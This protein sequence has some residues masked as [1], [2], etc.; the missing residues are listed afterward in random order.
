MAEE[1]INALAQVPGLRVAARTSTFVFKGK[2]HDLRAIG[3]KLNVA[4]VLEGS[5]RRAGNRVRITAQ[6]VSVSDGYHLWSERYDR[7]L[8]DIFAIQDEI[9]TAIASRLAVTLRGGENA[10][11]VRPSTS[12]LEAYELYLKAR[13]LLKERGPSLLVAIDLFERAVALDPG[14]APALA[15]LAQA[16]ILSSFWGMSAPERVIARATWAAATALEHDAGLVAAHVASALVATC[17]DFDHA[18]ATEAWNRALTIDPGDMDARTMRAAFDLCYTRG[19]FDASISELHAVVERDPLSASA[20]SQLSV[21]F[22]F[23]RRFEEAIAEAERARALAPQSFFVTWSYVNALAFG[24]DAREV[25]D[26]VPM[27][28]PRHGR[29]PWLMMGLAAAYSRLGLMEQADGIYTELVAR[30]RNE[31]VQPAVLA[32][33]A[34]L[35]GR[36]AEA[37][38]HLRRAVAIRDPL[39]SAFALHSP[40]MATLRS[41]P[42]FREILGGLSWDP[43]FGPIFALAPWPNAAPATVALP[44]RP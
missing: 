15:N 9:A 32:A 3:E 43:T 10:S 12:N 31:Y 18:R 41:A 2:N 36:R 5:V 26:R 20:H 30:S 29:N 40:P 37:L 28:L 13:S 24:G 19:E 17:V 7:E 22:S 38:D 35:A 25:V 21:I 44:S 11:L 8:T 33:A 34:D 6:L 27:L 23:A 4:T 16:L 1:I 42:E 39:L 14:F